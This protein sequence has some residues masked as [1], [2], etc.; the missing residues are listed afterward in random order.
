VS[1]RRVEEVNDVL[2]VGIDVRPVIVVLLDRLLGRDELA[3]VDGGRVSE[4]LEV[5]GQ[6]LQLI[7]QVLGL[8]N[9]VLVEV[10]NPLVFLG[11]GFELRLLLLLLQAH[12][13]GMLVLQLLYLNF[14][15]LLLRNGILLN[16]RIV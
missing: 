15:L 3:D 9:R 8:A 14:L 11:L 1:L 13:V 5:V 16:I 4:V 10:L 12:L 6:L 7:V 2:S